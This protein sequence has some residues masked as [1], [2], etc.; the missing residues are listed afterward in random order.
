MKNSAAVKDSSRFR[1][2]GSLSFV[3]VYVALG[4]RSLH[5]N[6]W[7]EA[8]LG[9]GPLDAPDFMA[10]GSTQDYLSEPGQPGMPMSAGHYRDGHFDGVGI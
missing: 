7:H 3:S 2:G 10:S 1:T 8:W 6:A 5:T 9:G 4:R